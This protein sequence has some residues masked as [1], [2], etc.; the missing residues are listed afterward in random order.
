[1]SWTATWF[2][3][4]F[5]LAPLD[6]HV[7]LCCSPLYHTAVLNFATISVQLGHPVVLDGLR[8]SWGRRPPW[9]R[10]LNFGNPEHAEVMWQLSEAIDGLS[11]ACCA[12]SLPVIGGNVSLYNESAGVDID[13]TPVIGV[14]GLV[15]DLR[16]PPPGLAWADGDAVGHLGARWAGDGSSPWKAAAGPS[17]A[18]AT[19]RFATDCRPRR[20]RAVVGVFARA[21]RRAGD[22]SL[23]HPPLL[24]ARRLGGRPR[25]RACGHGR[26]V[27][28]RLCARGGGCRRALHGAPSRFLVAT[29]DPDGRVPLPPR[30]ACSGG[31]GRGRATAWC[32]ASA[33]SSVRGGSRGLRRE[34]EQGVGQL[35]TAQA[36]A[37]MGNA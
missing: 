27:T 10:L 3:G 35:V 33:S 8:R 24:G 15:D 19:A 29:P 37:R 1:M 7:H 4:I 26:A 25:G 12:L 22:R 36:C 28:P 13:P 14:L 9:W 11:E 16:S 30:L 18:W 31:L 23:G 34:P 21:G 2:F 20:P 32:S 17:S 5:S 6:D